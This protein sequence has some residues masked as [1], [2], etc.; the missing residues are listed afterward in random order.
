VDGV[1]YIAYL[2]QRTVYNGV[3]TCAIV[4]SIDNIA[5]SHV[6]ITQVS[7]GQ[8]QRY[9]QV[10]A[11]PPKGEKT[12]ST[13]PRSSANLRVKN[14]DVSSASVYVV[15]T[16]TVP[17]SSGVTYEQMSSDLASSVRSGVFTTSLKECAVSLNL[18]VLTNASSTV[19]EIQNTTPPVAPVS[20]GSNSKSSSESM[21]YPVIGGIAFGGFAALA[22]VAY[23][24]MRFCV[25]PTAIAEL[26]E[27][28][29]ALKKRGM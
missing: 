19:A 7:P 16:I 18:T 27:K 2:M 17:A 21:S 22:I 11:V 13:A 5:E 14:H 24:G 12:S 3:F 1:D 4:A 20:I 25:K 10:V 28:Q 8:A 29:E 6:N 9:L 23:L 26:N 15:Y